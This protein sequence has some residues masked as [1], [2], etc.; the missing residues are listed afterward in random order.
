LAADRT[1][2]GVA[3][4]GR[5]SLEIVQAEGYEFDVNLD[6][7]GLPALHMDEP[8]P[9]GGRRGPNASRLLA[10]AVGNCLSA[11]LL[12]CLSKGEP[13]AEGLRTRVDCRVGRNERGRLR[14]TGLDVRI[15]LAA[16]LV[17]SPRLSR[18]LEL[19]EDFCVVTAS[20]RQ[21][22]PVAVEV[23]GPSGETLYRA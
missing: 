15:E 5:F 10:A 23:V 9:L 12:Y 8:P 14:V 11:S 18:C 13:P 1:E 22:L 16:A 20:V 3:D 2:E 17:A 4:E 7:P 21:G 6:W 19:F